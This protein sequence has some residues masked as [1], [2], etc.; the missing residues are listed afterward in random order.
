MNSYSFSVRRLTIIIFLFITN[1]S[2][3][4]QLC[5][6]C[7]RQNTSIEAG[8]INLIQN[9]SFEN[10]TC[11]PGSF[12]SF[13]NA[14]VNSN[15]SVSDWTCTGGGTLT[16]SSI[17][18]SN[19]AT[20][21][22]GKFA[23]YFGNMWAYVCSS[24]QWDTTCL[25]SLSCEYTGISSGYPYSDTLYGNDTGV[26]LEQ[27]VYGIIPGN[28]YILE[29]W[30]GGEIHN[31]QFTDPGIFA[32]DVGYG[33]HYLNCT[34]TFGADT[35][36]VYLIEFIASAPSHTI[37]FT[38]WGHMCYNC[39]ELV[40][41]NVKL[42]P[43]EYLPKNIPGCLIGIE[44]YGRNIIAEIYPSPFQNVLSVN[45]DISKEINLF[46]YDVTGRLVIYN[47]FIQSTEINTSQLSSGIYFIE[48]REGENS[49][50]RRK[51]IK[52]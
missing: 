13:C 46:L 9:G 24:T 42:Y 33:K 16:Y 4:Q 2:L 51:L 36:T 32:V 31:G 19:E 43:A 38:N 12:Q 27:T 44:D 45:V 37:K 14:S 20:I 49:L 28:R 1:N 21:S 7:Y 23:A 6:K 15:C 48:I 17:V 30:A 35:G 18:D 8:T 25:N 41:D 10:T 40:L 50:L 22:D 34:P 39:T 26:S 52:E 11:S 3:A 29:F 5:V 47:R